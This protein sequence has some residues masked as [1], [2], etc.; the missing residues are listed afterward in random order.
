MEEAS[1]G[2]SLPAALA[3]TLV[4]ASKILTADKGDD[5]DCN[6]CNNALM[7]LFNNALMILFKESNEEALLLSL[8]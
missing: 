2:L 8:S 6:D 1:E 3:A 5:H 7:I 4:A